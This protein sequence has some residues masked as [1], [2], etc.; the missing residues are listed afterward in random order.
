MNRQWKIL[1]WN[2]RG[3]NSD[4]KWGRIYDKI[5]ESNCAVIC[6]QET[7]R[8]LID[9]KFM[10][11]FCPK[12]FNKFEYLP[13]QGA[14]GGLLV[15][16]NDSVFVGELICQNNFDISV[17]FTST[18]SGQT[19]ILTNVYGPCQTE[20]RGNFIKWF[21]D[22]QVPDSVDWLVLGDFNFMRS[23]EDRNREGETQM[24]CF[25]LMML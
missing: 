2:V 4:H 6:F 22:I 18:C 13:S 5:E 1:N 23:P 19:W 14:S 12:R 10:K 17:E 16:W 21:R 7:K 25:C 20:E 24:T 9:S 8:E 15:A 11:N 3:L